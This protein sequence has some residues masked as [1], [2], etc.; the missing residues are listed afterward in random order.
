MI[1]IEIDA[2]PLSLDHPG[3][4]DYIS[5]TLLDA[6]HQPLLQWNSDTQTVG[7]AVVSQIDE[8]EGGHHWHLHI[9]PN[10]VW[11]NGRCITASDVL[12]GLTDAAAHP[13]WCRFL[14]VVNGADVVHDK[15]L[16][17]SLAR[18][19]SFLRHLLTSAHLAP[20]PAFDSPDPLF[21]GTHTLGVKTDNRL[22]LVPSPSHPNGSTAR[23]LAFLLNTDPGQ[24]V[25]GF[26]A[27][28][29]DVTSATGVPP[30]HLSNRKNGQRHSSSTG[31]F[32]QFEFSPESPLFQ[33]EAQR[34]ALAL[35]LD[36]QTLQQAIGDGIHASASYGPGMFEDLAIRPLSAHAPKEAARLWSQTDGPGHIAIAFNEYFPNAEL[37]AACAAQWE[38][39]LGVNVTPIPFAYGDEP[40]TD[41]EVV[42]ALRFPAFPHPWSI[43]D[44]PVRLTHLLTGNAEI[45]ADTARWLQT[46]EETELASIMNRISLAMPVIPLGEII[47]H[48]I[49]RSSSHAYR[50]NPDASVTLPTT[51]AAI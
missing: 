12:Q 20:K 22:E 23:H 13:F 45:W 30:A 7:P 32:A 33:S 4:P 14:N 43:L 1:G 26:D 5:R 6:L 49:A 44:Q 42:L 37:I 16:T 41:C 17:I 46:Q 10:A 15:L 24:S 9:S 35:A 29:W 50:I 47:G 27:G 48:W 11:H 21:S 25:A 34:R 18:P 40:P 51:E 36:A 39:T 28:P 2:Y 8:V 38:Q 3:L 19:V 31:I